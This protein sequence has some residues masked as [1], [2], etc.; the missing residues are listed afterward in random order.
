MVGGQSSRRLLNIN[1]SRKEEAEVWR[2]RPAPHPQNPSCLRKR[3]RSGCTGV[4]KR[5]IGIS[6]FSKKLSLQGCGDVWNA[7]RS[8]TQPHQRGGTMAP[9]IYVSL[10]TGFGRQAELLSIAR[11]CTHMCTSTLRPSNTHVPHLGSRAA[12]PRCWMNRGQ[13]RPLSQAVLISLSRTYQVSVLCL[14]AVWLQPW[15]SVLPAPI[16]YF[17]ANCSSF[18]RSQLK[19][20]FAR[21]P[22]PHLSL[23]RAPTPTPRSWRPVPQ[24]PAAKLSCSQLFGQSPPPTFTAAC[25]ATHL[26]TGT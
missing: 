4:I 6:M 15:G 8:H 25:S 2:G 9:L 23:S 18:H 7:A 19:G 3:E 21:R 16:L 26:G 12:H 20:H 24:Q 5:I 11:V 1:D 13:E 10:G 17:P 14:A 22:P